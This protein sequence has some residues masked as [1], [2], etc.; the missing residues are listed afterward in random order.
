MLMNV[1][2]KAAHYENY[3]EPFTGLTPLN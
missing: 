1:S 3:L 2:L